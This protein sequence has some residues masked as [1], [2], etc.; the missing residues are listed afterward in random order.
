MFGRTK[1]RKTERQRRETEESSAYLR[2]RRPVHV[3]PG[4]RAWMRR[5]LR[6]VL[7]SL[8]LAAIGLS[9]AYALESYLRSEARFLLPEDGVRLTGLHYLSP[10]KL[11]NVFASDLGTSVAGVP[12]EERQSQLN[13]IAWVER[14]AV[15]R[16]W[17]NRLW[18]H[19]DERQ[20][21][22]FV[23]VPRS[24]DSETTQ[25]IDRLG[26]FLDPPAGAAFT[27][28]VIAGVSPRMPFPERRE[29][30]ALFEKLIE[31]MDGGDPPYSPLLSEIDVSDLRNVRVTTTYGSEV[32]DLQMGNDQFRH[33]YA[34][35]LK[36][37]DG[38]K[39]EFGKVRAVDLRFEGQVAVR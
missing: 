21:V 18:V 37:I 25:L 1:E 36:Y 12:L 8:C 16:V 13:E 3:R 24:K 23:R 26:V 6:W 14:A 39:R 30:L 27:L 28:P 38:W 2:S 4:L 20:P 5:S 33:R 29:R 19:I 15:L 17:P 22:A 11:R 31:T 9:A 32:I 34:L 10:A 7:M 35:F